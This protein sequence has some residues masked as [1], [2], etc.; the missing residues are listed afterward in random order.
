VAGVLADNGMS[1]AQAVQKGE[2][3]DVVPLVFM[4][5]SAPARAVANALKG[6][7]EKGLLRAEP[8]SYRVLAR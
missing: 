4:T 5:H 1:I 2:N 7:K 6:L 3:T 8:V